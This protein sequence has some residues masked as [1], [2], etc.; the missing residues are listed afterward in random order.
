M[1]GTYVSNTDVE[2][3]VPDNCRV[4]DIGCATGKFA[5]V[6]KKKGCAVVGVDIDK[7]ALNLAAKYCEKTIQVDLDDLVSLDKKLKGEKFDCISFGDILEHI[8][9]PGVLLYHLK[10]YLKPQGLVLASIPNS[11]FIWLRIRFSLGNFDY[12]PEGGLMDEDHIRFFSFKTARI[13][14]EDAQYK[15][16]KIQGSS[17]GIV[18]KK[19][20][21][22]KYFAKIAPT[23]FAIHVIV[24]GQN[25]R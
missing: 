23:L 24:L 5:R 17:H 4:L 14:F 22:I 1:A 18:N 2:K 10:K 7:T 12:M 25:K 13:L 20:W 16:L 9:Y 11:A 15:V 3:M 21:F 6:L 19:F 8:K